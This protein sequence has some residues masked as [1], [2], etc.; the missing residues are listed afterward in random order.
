MTPCIIIGSAPSLASCVATMKKSSALPHGH[1]EGGS[2]EHDGNDL[3]YVP[4]RSHG[5]KRR[6]KQKGKTRRPLFT[7]GCG[8]P[9]LF[10]MLRLSTLTQR[11]LFFLEWIQLIERSWMLFVI[12]LPNCLKSKTNDDTIFNDKRIKDNPSGKSIFSLIIMCISSPYCLF[13]EGGMEREGRESCG[14]RL[15]A[16][17]IVCLRNVLWTG[18]RSTFRA[19]STV[20]SPICTWVRA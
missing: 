2:E 16:M 7:G 19:C 9:S 3:D 8:K 14:P 6:K 13:P 11:S 18:F 12:H 4:N 5:A 15:R 1:K 20:G 10:V 17:W